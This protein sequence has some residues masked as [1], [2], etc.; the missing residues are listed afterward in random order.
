VTLY[1]FGILA[2][3]L[4][5]DH[6]DEEIAGTFCNLNNSLWSPFKMMT[7]DG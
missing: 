7:M 2:T 6:P 4:L 1:I 3:N 5:W